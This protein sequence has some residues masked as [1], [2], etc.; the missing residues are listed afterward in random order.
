MTSLTR[1]QFRR[2]VLENSLR[3]AIRKM[4]PDEA[5]TLAMAP[6]P[7]AP[8]TPGAPNKVEP[9]GDHKA[10]FDYTHLGAKGAALF[11]R[12]VANELIEA[13]P[14]LRACFNF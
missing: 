5:N 13:V 12:V 11:G 10:V 8:N 1:R 6:P 9:N 3:A 7:K 2:G 4:G 14:A